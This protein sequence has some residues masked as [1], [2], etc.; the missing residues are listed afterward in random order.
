MT[1]IRDGWLEWTDVLRLCIEGPCRVYGIQDKGLLTPGVHGD[2]VVVD[3]DHTGPITADWLE[4]RSP[5]NPFIG[6]ELA[7]K[8]ITTIVRGKVVYDA[9]Q[10]VGEAPGQPLVFR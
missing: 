1:A 2:V 8:P 7:G 10:V 3:P 4:S 5:C 6:R 9:G